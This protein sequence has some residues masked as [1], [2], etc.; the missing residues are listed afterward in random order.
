MLH[1]SVSATNIAGCSHLSVALPLNKQNLFQEN[2]K[3][4]C[5]YAPC[6]WECD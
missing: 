1:V 4:E 5:D 6:Q 2:D 3:W